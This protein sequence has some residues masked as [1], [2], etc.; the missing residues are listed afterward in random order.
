MQGYP[1]GF[2]E[3]RGIP[4]E[5]KLLP[6]Y[7]KE[8]GYATHMVGKWHSG[9]SRR[10]YLPT[11]RGFD[12]F[13]GHVG[14]FI[15]YYEYTSEEP[16]PSGKVSGMALYKNLTPAWDVEGYITDVYTEKATSIIRNHDKSKPLFLNVAHNAPH[17]GNPGAVLQASP[18][19]VSAMRHVESPG[20]RIF[21]AMVK[22]LDD[23]IGDIMAALLEKGMLQN[24]IIAFVSDNGG[25]SSGQTM[26]YA[27]NWP[28]RGLKMTPF[29]GGVRVAGLLWTR[30]INHHLLKGYMHAV[31]W[32]PTLLRA[33]G[34]DVPSGID[35]IDLW[36][37]ITLNKVSPRNEIFDITDDTAPINYS[38]IVS[39]PYKLVTG[40]V[41]LSYS[42]YQGEDLRGVIGDIPLYNKSLKE[43]KMFTVLEK[44]GKPFNVADIDLR[45]KM[46]ID[47]KGKERNS[48][49]ACYPQNGKVVCLFNIIDDPC[50]TTDISEKYPDLVKDLTERLQVELKQ[51]IPRTHGYFDARSTPSLFNYTWTT[52]ID[53]YYHVQST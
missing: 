31:D 10:E 1:I 47:C 9:G 52:F 41:V 7:L 42:N 16:W 40:D 2:S 25:M 45:Y 18:K 51:R 3:D 15:D 20:R 46:K 6:Q 35:G 44:I 32:L 14:G 50:E 38:A 33:V 27:S 17:A 49:S 28:L 4:V 39:G 36:D 26:N 34:A 24:S 11:E 5:E 29:E 21:A 53:Y 48:G 23:S 19:D 13:F 43:S 8:L 12:S 22:K 30:Q 37:E